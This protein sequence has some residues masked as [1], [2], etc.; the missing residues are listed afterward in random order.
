[1]MRAFAQAAQIAHK[2]ARMPL[3]RIP[4]RLLWSVANRQ[5]PQVPAELKYD[6]QA[7]RMRYDA[8]RKACVGVVRVR[9]Y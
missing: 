5:C 9:G 6:L 7:N 8:I 4:R 2:M 3:T 1:M